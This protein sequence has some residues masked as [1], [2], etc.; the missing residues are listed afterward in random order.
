MCLIWTRCRAHLI[1]P[2][3]VNGEVEY[4]ECPL[5]Q[6]MAKCGVESGKRFFIHMD[7]EVDELQDE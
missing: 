4:Y 3:I 7:E 2:K 5:D 1:V 6:T